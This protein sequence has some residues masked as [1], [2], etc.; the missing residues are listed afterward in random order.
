MAVS[1]YQQHVYCCAGMLRHQTALLDCAH[2]PSAA[3]AHYLNQFLETVKSQGIT[4]VSNQ[5]VCG[6]YIM[7]GHT[8]HARSTHRGDTG[9][10]ILGG[11]VEFCLFLCINLSHTS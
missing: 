11:G 7:L 4:G 2:R 8:Q 1:T 10:I 3:Q 5:S 9:R 6:T